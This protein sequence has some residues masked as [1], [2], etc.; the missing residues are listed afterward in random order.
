MDDVAALKMVNDFVSLL[1][2]ARKE[3]TS[4]PAMLTALGRTSFPVPQKPQYD[5]VALD[6][7]ASLAPSW[8]WSLGRQRGFRKLLVA[9]VRSV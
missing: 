7:G 8:R 9:G 4:G 2:V 5:S 6:Q 1:E 3:Y